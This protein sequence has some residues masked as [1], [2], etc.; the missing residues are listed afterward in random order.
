MQCYALIKTIE[1]IGYSSEILWEQGTILKNYDFRIRK[2]L[3]TS[4]RLLLHPKLIC[5]TVSNVADISTKVCSENTTA[6]F[7]EFS[8]KYIRQRKLP[9]RQLKKTAYSDEYFKF[10]C[11]SDQIWSS[12]TLYNDPLLYL[13]FAPKEKRIAYAPSIGRDYIP[14]FNSRTMKKYINGVNHLSVRE[15]TGNKL[16]KELTGRY[17][18]VVLDPTLLIEKDDWAKIARIDE[19]D[20]SDEKY[21]LC[22]FLDCPSKKVQQQIYEFAKN[23][24][25]KIIALSSRLEYLEKPIQV[26]YPD[27]GP[28]EFIGYVMRATHVCTDSYHGMIFS[29]I[30]QK[31]FYS[32]KRNYSFFD[33]SSRQISLLEILKL[34]DRYISSNAQ[35]DILSK[36]IEYKYVEPILVSERKKSINFLKNALA[37]E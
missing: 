27:C 18:E 37:G 30:M 29:I 35:P 7:N 9:H 10:V 13:R 36:E 12:T 31:S 14:D 26:K 28:Q 25:A 17:A 21:V 24:N 3:I 32:F 15:K 4:F 34:E 8:S 22:Y 20:G 23:M 19:S 1:D 33:Q 6:M 11:G 16:I 5:S 2:I